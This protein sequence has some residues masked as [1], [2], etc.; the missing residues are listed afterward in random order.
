MRFKN[1]LYED[2]VHVAYYKIDKLPQ[3]KHQN[4]VKEKGWM[5]IDGQGYPM[6]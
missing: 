1:V 2:I 5:P 3:A 4:I 6:A